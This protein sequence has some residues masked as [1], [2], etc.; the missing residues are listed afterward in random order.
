MNMN[1]KKGFKN[2]VSSLIIAAGL[3]AMSAPSYSENASDRSG[4]RQEARDTK[5]EGRGEARDTKADCKEGNKSN[6]DCRQGKR[7][8]KQKSKEEARDIKK[9]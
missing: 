1:N 6:S 4:N 3:L 5:Q 9:N 7:D 2:V 8:D